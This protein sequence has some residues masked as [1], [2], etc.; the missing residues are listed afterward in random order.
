MT[1]AELLF[2]LLLVA[3]VA[4]CLARVNLQAVRRERDMYRHD[5]THNF[6]VADAQAQ[7]A[8]RIGQELIAAHVAVESANA[9]MRDAFAQRDAALAEKADLQRRLATATKPKVASHE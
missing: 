1:A 3:V 4:Y 2:D 9:A 7:R 5:A 6:D 8:E